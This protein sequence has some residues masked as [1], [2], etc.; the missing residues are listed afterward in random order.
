MDVLNV[1]LTSINPP[2]PIPT[3]PPLPRPRP[4]P[5][6]HTTTHPP[7]HTHTLNER[8]SVWRHFYGVGCKFDILKPTKLHLDPSCMHAL[9]GELVHRWFRYWPVAC[10]QKQLPDSTDVFSNEPPGISFRV[11]FNEFIDFLSQ[12]RLC[13]LH[14]VNLFSFGVS[15]LPCKSPASECFH[16]ICTE[17]IQAHWLGSHENGGHDDW[18]VR[19]C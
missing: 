8:Q 18:R 4:P 19:L 10:L 12:K 1:K 14:M 15:I 6:R 7:H 5:P 9:I 16:F 13:I 11:F 17:R 3:P 2:T